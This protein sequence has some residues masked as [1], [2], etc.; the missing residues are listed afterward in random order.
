MELLKYFNYEKHYK[1]NI[2]KITELNDFDI[3]I[4]KI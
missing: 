2:I 1:S 4:L 3:V